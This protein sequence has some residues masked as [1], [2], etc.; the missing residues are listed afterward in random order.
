M[1]RWPR[2]GEGGVSADGL[3]GGIGC[4]MRAG[5]TGRGGLGG[6]AGRTGIDGRDG[7]VGNDSTTSTVSTRTGLWAA[8]GVIEHKLA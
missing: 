4:L 2:A 5:T 7:E 1:G 6:S 3:G 8:A